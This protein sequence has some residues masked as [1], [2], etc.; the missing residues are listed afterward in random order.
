MNDNYCN[1][2]GNQLHLGFLTILKV[3]FC[4]LSWM[5]R[6]GT[7]K[8]PLSAAVHPNNDS[9][10]ITGRISYSDNSFDVDHP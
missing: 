6:G 1:E 2:N 7:Y 9:V 3:G 10:N 4:I 5:Q 8:I